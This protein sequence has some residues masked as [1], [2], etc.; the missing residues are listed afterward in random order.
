VIENIT[1]LVKEPIRDII[2]LFAKDFKKGTK[3]KIF[4]ILINGYIN[5]KYKSVKNPVVFNI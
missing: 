5:I 3:A 4:N 2:A 1:L